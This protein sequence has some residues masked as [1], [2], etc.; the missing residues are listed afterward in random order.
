MARLFRWTAIVPLCLL[1]LLLAA[2]WL[3]YADR[4][5]QHTVEDYGADLR[6]RAGGY[7]ERGPEAQ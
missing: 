1:L 2:A 6:R 5:V 7:R 3:L 4:L